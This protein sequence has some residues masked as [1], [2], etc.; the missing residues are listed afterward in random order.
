MVDQTKLSDVA[1]NEASK[2]NKQ[3]A[4]TNAAYWHVQLSADDVSQQDQS[5]WQAWL[6]ADEV[7][8]NADSQVT[9]PE[10]NQ[11]SKK[12]SKQFS[13][14]SLQSKPHS[15]ADHDNISQ[16]KISHKNQ[17]LLNQWAWQQV[18][19]LQANLPNSLGTNLA[20]NTLSNI[21]PYVNQERRMRCVH[22]W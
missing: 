17:V 8:A 12:I 4:L 21:E 11:A 6:N 15:Q 13:N 18:E 22:L 19:Q 16:R 1:A 3:Q 20:V 14:Q 2:K 10:N 9:K 5:A 7:I